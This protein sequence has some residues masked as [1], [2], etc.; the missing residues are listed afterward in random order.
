M[1]TGLG[2]APRIRLASPRVL[3]EITA[4][5]RLISR[6]LAGAPSAAAVAGVFRLRQ[7]VP[8]DEP[9][10]RGL[11]IPLGS[12][13]GRP[14]GQAAAHSEPELNGHFQLAK[15]EASRDRCVSGRAPRS[16][17]LGGGMQ[18]HMGYH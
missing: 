7:L 2:I 5:S 16:P 4:H 3:P 10:A 12:R 18:S 17:I 8:V 13:A 14:P 9:Q 1:R 15:T 6:S 11:P